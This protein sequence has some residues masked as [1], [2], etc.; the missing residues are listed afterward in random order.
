MKGNCR[1][2]EF[3]KKFGFGQLWRGLET[4]FS[5][6]PCKKKFNW[7]EVMF[8]AEIAE[9]EQRFVQTKFVVDE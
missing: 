7:G 9:T 3:E 1:A 4:I 8:L 5:P 2:V 6:Q